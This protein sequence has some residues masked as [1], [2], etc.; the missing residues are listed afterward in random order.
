MLQ[1]GDP[2]LIVDEAI[3]Y[4]LDNPRHIYYKRVYHMFAL[5]REDLV[6]KL[7]D[8][9]RLLVAESLSSLLQPADHRRWSADENLDIGS[10]LGEPFLSYVSHSSPTVQQ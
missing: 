5:E 3:T 6:V 10:G 2:L 7:A 4:A 8:W 9:S 1:D